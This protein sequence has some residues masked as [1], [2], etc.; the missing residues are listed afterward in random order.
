MQIGYTLPANW[1]KV[2][3]IYKTRVYA[4][5]QNLLTFSHL[6]KYNID[7]EQPGVSNGYYPQQRIFSFGLNVTF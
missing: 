4:E 3:G 5:G 2:A 6:T 1:M 7:P